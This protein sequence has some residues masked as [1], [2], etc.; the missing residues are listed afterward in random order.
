MKPNNQAHG[1]REQIGGCQRWGVGGQNE[2]KESQDTVQT[3][4]YKISHGV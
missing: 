2:W 3:S 1:L 4:R